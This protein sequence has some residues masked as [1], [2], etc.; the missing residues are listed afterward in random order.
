MGRLH[1]QLSKTNGHLG[2]SAPDTDETLR[3]PRGVE[4]ALFLG[5]FAILLSLMYLAYIY[6]YPDGKPP[7][8]S[9]FVQIWLREIL[10]LSFVALAILYA[11]VDSCIRVAKRILSR[12]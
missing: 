12:D 9:S 4:T 6:P 2:M 3:T 5:A 10:I 8:I 7:E 11:L 1:A